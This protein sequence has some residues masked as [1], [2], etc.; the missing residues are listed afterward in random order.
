MKEERVRNIWPAV[1]RNTNII[2]NRNANTNTKGIKG[3]KDEARKRKEIWPAV[4]LEEEWLSQT[5]GSG[6]L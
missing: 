5:M 2:T 6:Q 3:T 1:Y 4:Y